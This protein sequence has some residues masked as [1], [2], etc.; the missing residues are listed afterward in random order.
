M[1]SS[2][3]SGVLSVNI[4]SS[5]FINNTATKGGAIYILANFIV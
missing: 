1:A 2:D 4:L 5:H 3:E